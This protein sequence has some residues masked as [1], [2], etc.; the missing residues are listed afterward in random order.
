MRLAS[1]V[2]LVVSSV[3]WSANGVSADG[4]R[5]GLLSSGSATL[6]DDA[7]TLRRPLLADD[8]NTLRR[9]LVA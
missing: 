3:L 4:C 9:P 2:A 7:N 5:G 1:I 6:T 8:A